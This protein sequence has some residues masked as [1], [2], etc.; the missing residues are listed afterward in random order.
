LVIV[1]MFISLGIT[2]NETL[3][4]TIEKVNAY[5]MTEN[6]IGIVVLALQTLAEQLESNIEDPIS[7]VDRIYDE[8]RLEDVSGLINSLYEQHRA[9]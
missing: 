9:K 7:M 8:E 4:Q 2:K 1:E 6:E 3:M 5:K